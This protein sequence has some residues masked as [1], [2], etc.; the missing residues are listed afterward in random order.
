MS[1]GAAGDGAAAA[2]DLL[3]G[4]AGPIERKRARR[5]GEGAIRASALRASV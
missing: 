3:R 1:G 4:R 2:P 5:T